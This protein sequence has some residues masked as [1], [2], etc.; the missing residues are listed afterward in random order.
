VA[1]QKQDERED[2]EAKEDFYKWTRKVFE[3]SHFSGAE[4]SKQAKKIIL[5]DR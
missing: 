2:D 4:E 1:E 5:Q 3:K